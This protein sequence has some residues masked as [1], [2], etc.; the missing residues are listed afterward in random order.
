M[1]IRED[2][3]EEESLAP[4]SSCH[5]KGSH[6]DA[7]SEEEVEDEILESVSTVLLKIKNNFNSLNSFFF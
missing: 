4:T 7:E 1:G 3:H 2:D 5:P 6:D